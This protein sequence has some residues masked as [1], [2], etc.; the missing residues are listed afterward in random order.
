MN[1][2]ER[3]RSSGIAHRKYPN[4]R[5]GLDEGLADGRRDDRVLAFA[6]VSKGIAHKMNPAA[7]P[8]GADHALDRG[9]QSLMCIGASQE[10]AR[11]D[12]I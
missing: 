7:L 5:G 9:F 8:T 1:P 10:R 12:S 6:H 4:A 11:A 3:I 2:Y